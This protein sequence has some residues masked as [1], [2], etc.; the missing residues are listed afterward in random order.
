M[1]DDAMQRQLATLF[2]GAKRAKRQKNRVLATYCMAAAICGSALTAAG[3]YFMWPS[4]VGTRIAAENLQEAIAVL[5]WAERR[6]A[7]TLM[8]AIEAHIGKRIGEFDSS[9]RARAVEFLLGQVQWPPQRVID[10]DSQRYRRFIAT[11]NDAP[12]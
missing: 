10:E 5:S 12:T 6:D 3:S 8:M 4:S 1:L 11:S 2:E 7:V 9:D